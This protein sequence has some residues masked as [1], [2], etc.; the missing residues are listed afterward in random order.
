MSKLQK[1]SNK[2]AMVTFLISALCL[3][4][5]A[6]TGSA[7]APP[8][9]EVF[10]APLTIAGATVTVGAPVNISTNPGYDN[11][12]SFLPN[13]SG[14]LFASNRDGKQNDIYR[15][16]IAKKALV[17]LTK[18]AE[19]E[20]SP[21]VAP[22]G[23]SFVCVHGT[24]QSLFRYDLDGANPRLAYQHGKE[25]IGYH[26][27]INDTQLAAFVLGATG[28]PNTLQLIDTTTG[29]SETLASA[30]GRSLLKRPGTS[31]VS[32]VAK[33]SAQQWYLKT[34]DPKTKVQSVV[35]TDLPKSTEDLTWLPDGR[36]IM[37]QGSKLV[38][39][40][41][42]SGWKEIADL[43]AGGVTKITRLS[44]SPDGKWLAIVGEPVT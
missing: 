5:F 14:V 40:T 6:L 25:L 19:N 35:A 23:K 44:A 22:D 28:Q 3:L 1:L 8:A 13:S 33:V 37:G 36:F 26:V 29:K 43:T 38:M 31:T 7:Q 27:W 34:F 11:Q 18:T 42:G 32:Y 20:Y 15:W 21:L 12:P 41:L 9:T 2:L 24:E 4:P 30:I 10:L 17:Q 39:W 16:D